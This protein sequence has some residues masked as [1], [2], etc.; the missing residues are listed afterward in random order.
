MKEQDNCHSN[1]S[2]KRNKGKSKKFNSSPKLY[3]QTYWPK[4]MISR[5]DRIC[6]RNEKPSGT[7]CLP[8]LEGPTN[9]LQPE[10]KGKEAV[11]DLYCEK[12]RRNFEEEHDVCLISSSSEI[13]RGLGEALP[14][15]GQGLKVDGSIGNGERSRLLYGGEC[16]F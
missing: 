12:N 1:E 6:K 2:S 10:D 11:C 14:E 7:T 15:N 8:F 3:I 9:K 4:V 13:Q 16:D 5:D